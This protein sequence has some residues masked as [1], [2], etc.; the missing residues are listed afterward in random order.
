VADVR[1]VKN[2][3][4]GDTATSTQTFTINRPT[5]FASGND[6]FATGKLFAIRITNGG[7]S[8][9]FVDPFIAVPTAAGVLL[10]SNCPVRISAISTS[11]FCSTFPADNTR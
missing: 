8:Y 4:C 2:I 3:A 1:I 5:A 7:A 11:G 9:S 10:Q 6:I